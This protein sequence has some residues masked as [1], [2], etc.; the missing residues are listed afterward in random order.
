[1]AED[2]TSTT[3]R[4][5]DNIA[6]ID[7]DA[8]ADTNTDE[9]ATRFILLPAEIRLFIYD[10]VFAS[11][12][13]TFGKRVMDNTNTAHAARIKR[14]RSNSLALLRVCRLIYRETRDLWLNLV[15]FNFEDPRTLLDKLT[16]LSAATVSKIRRLRVWAESL[17]FQ[18]DL[19]PEEGG[20]EALIQNLEQGG[21]TEARAVLS[22]SLAAILK[23]VPALRLDVLT[24]FC[25]SDDRTAWQTLTALVKKGNGWRQLNFVTPNSAPLMW[26]LI[27]Q[28]EEPDEEGDRYRIGLPITW[29]EHLYRRDGGEKSGAS[30]TIYRRTTPDTTTTTA[31]ATTTT[32]SILCPEARQLF[33]EDDILEL[34]VVVKRG[35]NANIAEPETL[36]AVDLDDIR[37]WSQGMDW[38]EIRERALSMSESDD[39]GEWDVDDDVDVEEDSYEDVEEFEW[40]R[41]RGWGSAIL[42]DI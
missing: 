28:R 2:D 3:T 12:R 34:L 36:S 24:V 15:L 25:S 19:Q 38:T 39:A 23:L 29:E 27:H 13:L 17:W 11:T 26:A 14:P 37:A 8:D 4:A 20:I 21:G 42:V 1:M 7:A 22:Y 9:P 5:D 16:P 32:P 33:N 6:P 40:P 35:R 18:T 30:V 41:L 10:F 31:D